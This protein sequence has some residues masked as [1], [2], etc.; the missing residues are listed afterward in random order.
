MCVFPKFHQYI[1]MV[2]RN[3]QNMLHVTA[4]GTRGPNRIRAIGQCN[5]SCGFTQCDNH[6]RLRVKPM[7]VDRLVIL[8]VSDKSNALEPNRSHVFKIRL[9]R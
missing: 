8:R 1:E 2:R 6:F 7:H 4:A 5:F 9:S 3:L